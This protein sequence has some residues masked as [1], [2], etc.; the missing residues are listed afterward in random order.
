MNPTLAFEQDSPVTCAKQPEAAGGINDLPFCPVFVVGAP[1]SGT[2]FIHSLACTS[3]RANP[4]TPEYHYFYL[5]LEAYVRSLSSFS[6]SAS[7]G[8]GSKEEF[9]THHFKVMKDA[10]LVMWAHLGKPD[11]LV[12]KHCSL[13]PFL[14]ILGR[15]FPT[16][17]FL[18]IQR[19][20]RDSVASE[21]RAVR[22]H[23][24]DPTALPA[25]VVDKAVARYNFYYGSLVAAAT[26]IAGRLHCVRYEEL[27]RG[28][29]IDDIGRFLGFSDIDPRKL[30]KRAT[31][32][33][34]DFSDFLLHSELWGTPMS[35]KHVGRYQETLPEDVSHRIRERTKRVSLAFEA[36]CPTYAS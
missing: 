25:E 36:L 30:W 23:L 15:K 3:E 1:R 12:M 20:A 19:D 4:F 5:L 27:V 7:A 33:I 31:F 2:H 22:R 13:T 21:I 18:A 26:D 9:T 10:L 29:G 34:G 17:K 24:A 6:A 28:R 8:F 11:S 16:M 14:P 32:D 35:A